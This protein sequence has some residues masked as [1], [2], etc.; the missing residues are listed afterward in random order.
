V[1]C[2]AKTTKF[3]IYKDGKGE[4]RWRLLS[5]N[6]ESVAVGGEGYGARRGAITAIK[7][8]KDWASTDTIE[9]V[10]K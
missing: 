7:K 2:M 6:G 8:L 3:Q 1:I 5:R 10:E 9:D 4:F